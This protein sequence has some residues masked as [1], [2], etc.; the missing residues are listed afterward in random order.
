MEDLAIAAHTLYC[1]EQRRMGATPEK[2]PALRPWDELDEDL[3]D[4][5][6]AQVTDITRKLALLGYELAATHGLSPSSIHITDEQCDQLSQKEHERWMEERKRQGWTYAPVRDNAKKLH[7]SLIPYQQLAETE[8]KKDR[9]VVR[10]IPKLIE[11]AGFRVRKIG[12]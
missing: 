8:K 2:T 12:Q 6:R 10:S 11:K 9:D 7:P 3:R 1:E 5:N 4:A